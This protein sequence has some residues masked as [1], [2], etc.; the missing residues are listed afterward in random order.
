MHQIRMFSAYLI[1]GPVR[2][3]QDSDRL[4][5]PICIAVTTGQS[6][7]TYGLFWRRA[8]WIEQHWY[9]DLCCQI[10]SCAPEA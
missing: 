9:Y 6:C 4:I 5:R 8:W 1:D 2:G 3:H 7:E 10:A